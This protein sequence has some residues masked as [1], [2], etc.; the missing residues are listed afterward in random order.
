MSI[1]RVSLSRLS[2]KRVRVP[3]GSPQSQFIAVT[4]LVVA[5]G[6]GGYD[7][8]NQSIYSR[9]GGGG[10]GGYRAGTTLALP[11]ETMTVAVGGGGGGYSSG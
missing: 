4:Y 10:G 1:N 11:G 7:G 6:G 5:G 8:S 9:G 2:L 3:F